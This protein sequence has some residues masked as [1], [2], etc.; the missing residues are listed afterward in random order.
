MRTRL[1]VCSLLLSL[2]A[3]S[4]EAE[5]ATRA[6]SPGEVPASGGTSIEHVDAAGAAE[7]LTDGEVVVLDLRTPE[8]FDSGH[9]AGAL[10]VDYH[11]ADFQ[12]QLGALDKEPTYLVLC[13]VGWR[14]TRS[15]PRFERAG[16]ARIAHL[17]GGM[18]AWRAAGLPVVD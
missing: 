15:L 3:C 12:E 16:F 8:E 10:L 5:Q 1:A 4:K 13:E 2:S 11:A 6:D 17:D 7:L 14:S 9:L 18:R